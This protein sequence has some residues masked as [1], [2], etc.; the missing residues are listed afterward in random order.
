MILRPICSRNAPELSGSGIQ[1][2]RWIRY[3][4][5]LAPN[6]SARRF[7]RVLA[8]LTQALDRL[9]SAELK[10]FDQS[11]HSRWQDVAAEQSKCLGELGVPFFIDNGENENKLKI[12]ALLE[13]LIQGD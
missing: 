4:C 3:S 2:V 7:H 8:L 10:I 13:D 12:L 9:E 6:A 5:P 11:I 1:N